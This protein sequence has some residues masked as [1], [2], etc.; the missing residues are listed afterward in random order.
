[1][2]NTKKSAGTFN[3]FKNRRWSFSQMCRLWIR[4]LFK[5][6]QTRLRNEDSGLLPWVSVVSQ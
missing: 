2:Q 5:T 6:D 1:M 4:L 3:F